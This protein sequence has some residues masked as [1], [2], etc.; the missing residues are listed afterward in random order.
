[1]I[2]NGGR[3]S[4]GTYSDSGIV[5][6]GLILNLDA[7][8]YSGSGST[9]PAT[10]GSNATL[11]TS[12]PTYRNTPPNYFEFV[13]AYSNWASVPSLGDLSSW[14]VEVWFNP[15]VDLSTVP[16]NTIVTTV[17]D[18]PSGPAPHE[19]N[20]CL[21][22]YVYPGSTGNGISVGFFNG[23]WHLNTMV[24]TTPGTWYQMV[25][26]YD[27][28][29]MKQYA[30]GTFSSQLTVGETSSANGGD[31]WIARRWDGAVSDIN[32]F[33]GDISIIRIYNTALNT[34]QVSQNY[35]AYKGRFGL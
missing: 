34:S 31:V 5:S 19:I 30:N 17:Y 7:L 20:F 27:G 32:L 28:T 35:N 26:T 3:L 33:P 4:G 10:V 22:N 29:T 24:A 16:I 1:M 8:Q 2:I 11:S 23:N 12:P 14:T 13:P 21:T 25:G 9:W 6:A 18:D 15:T